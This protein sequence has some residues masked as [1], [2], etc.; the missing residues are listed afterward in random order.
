MAR[1]SLEVFELMNSKL[2][3]QISLTNAKDEDAIRSANFILEGFTSSQL[4]MIKDFIE[5]FS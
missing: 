2:D 4:E 5:S 3:K 1:I